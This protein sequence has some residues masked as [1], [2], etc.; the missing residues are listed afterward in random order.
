MKKKE[1]Q[2]KLPKA[3]TEKWLEALRSG[4]YKQGTGGLKNVGNEYCC[5]GVYAELQNCG[6]KGGGTFLDSGGIT[7]VTRIPRALRGTIGLPKR[8]AEM[9]DG[10]ASM[11]KKGFKGIAQWIERNVELVDEEV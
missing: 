5:L 3:S 8:L 7:A 11:K 2:W 10:T 9:N 1:K 4:K 6:I